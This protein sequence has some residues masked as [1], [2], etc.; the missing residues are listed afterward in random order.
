MQLHILVD[1][2]MQHHSKIKPC[3]NYSG[4]LLNTTPYSGTTKDAKKIK[5]QKKM[6]CRCK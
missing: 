5:Y 6:F 4:K 1:D 3:N 2:M